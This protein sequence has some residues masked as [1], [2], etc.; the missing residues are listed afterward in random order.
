MPRLCGLCT[1]GIEFL[2]FLSLANPL[3]YRIDALHS[4]DI[5]IVFGKMASTIGSFVTD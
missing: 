1:E 4:S 3:P 5:R 2:F